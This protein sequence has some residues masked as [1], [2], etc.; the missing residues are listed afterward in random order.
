MVEARSPHATATPAGTVLH[1]LDISRADVLA[2]VENNQLGQL[3]GRQGLTPHAFDRIQR[4]PGLAVAD[5]AHRRQRRLQVAARTQA[6]HLVDQAGGEHAVEALGDAPQSVLIRK[7]GAAQLGHR[8]KQRL[9][10]GGVGAHRLDQLARELERYKGRNP[11]VLAIPRGGVP[12]GRA[13]ADALIAM[14]LGGKLR[15]ESQVRRDGTA[16]GIVVSGVDNA[17]RI[18][19][20]DLV[21]DRGGHGI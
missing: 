8:G 14:A 5:A 20:H 16:G 13:I 2:A 21:P 1:P 11:L 4:L 10:V 18:V 9:L 17:R 12:M 6:T 15:E 7:G 3:L 19:A